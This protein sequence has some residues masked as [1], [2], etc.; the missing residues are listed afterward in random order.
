MRALYKHTFSVHRVGGQILFFPSSPPW[1]A[2]MFPGAVSS[3][4]RVFLVGVGGWFWGGLGWGVGCVFFLLPPG[5]ICGPS[6]PRQRF[7]FPAPGELLELRRFLRGFF[8]SPF[9]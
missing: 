2:V 1:V 9:S 5:G 6:S 8:E 7:P 3:P 4:F